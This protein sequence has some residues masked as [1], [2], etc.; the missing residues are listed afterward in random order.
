MKR[1]GT[2]LLG[3]K[4]FLE[5]GE[6]GSEVP[7]D[8]ADDVALEAANDFFLGESFG[9]PSGHVR[10]G[11]GAVAEPNDDDQVQRSVG[12]AVPAVVEAMAVRSA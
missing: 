11:L 6:V 5:G 3:V 4:S 2:F 1:P 10:L 7:M 9:E 12:L 8:L